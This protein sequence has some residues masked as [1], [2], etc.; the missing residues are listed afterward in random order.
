MTHPNGG[1]LNT[2]VLFGLWGPGDKGDISTEHFNQNRV[3]C[4]KFGHLAQLF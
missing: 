3:A 1:A 2:F 4:P